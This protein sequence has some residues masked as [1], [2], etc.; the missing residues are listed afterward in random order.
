MN[1]NQKKANIH[2]LFS[3]FLVFDFRIEDIIIKNKTLPCCYFPS[4]AILVDDNEHFLESI[5]F[6]LSDK[7]AYQLYDKPYQALEF[8]KDKYKSCLTVDKWVALNAQNP[9]STETHPINI[10]INAIYQELYNQRRFNEVSIVLVDYSMPSMNGL[11]FCQHIRDLPIKKVLLTGEADLDVAVKAFNE[12]IIDQ[13]IRKDA[14]NFVG[15]VNQIIFELQ[16]NYFQDFSSVISKI[17]AVDPS[18]PLEDANF[19]EFFEDV[20]K[21]KQIM[22]FYLFEKSGSFLLLDMEAKP[23]WL[24]VKTKNSLENLDWQNYN[25]MH[26]S[27][28]ENFKG[29]N[30][31]DV[32][33]Y[34]EYLGL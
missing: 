3:G 12:G 18:Y 32:L 15:K 4:T 31:A 33:S 11:E 28:S 25:G 10:N 14:Y 2:T 6:K 21:E 34:K 17:L 30:T 23:W 16:K 1:V 27:L 26:Y 24:T 5:V 13:F 19:I 9:V 7:L 29:I 20:C 8:L 22:E